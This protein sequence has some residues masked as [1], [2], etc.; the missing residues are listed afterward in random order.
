MF[1]IVGFFP[2]RGF[3]VKV[4]TVHKEEISPNPIPPPKFHV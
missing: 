4:N 2:S 3:I 1:Y